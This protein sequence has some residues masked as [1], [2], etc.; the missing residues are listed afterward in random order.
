MTKFMMPIFITTY[1]RGSGE[2]VIKSIKRIVATGIVLG[3]F[4]NPAKGAITFAHIA[5]GGPPGG[6]QYKA[7]LQVSSLLDE[8]SGWKVFLYPTGNSSPSDGRWPAPYSYNGITVQDG[9]DFSFNLLPHESKFFELTGDHE[10][11]SGWMLIENYLH[12]SGDFAQNSHSSDSLAVSLFLQ[13]G[14]GKV[15]IGSTGTSQSITGREQITVPIM[16]TQSHGRQEIFGVFDG[17]VSTTVNTGVA[18]LAHSVKSTGADVVFTL[19]GENGEE[20]DRITTGVSSGN[21]HQ[22]RFIHEI[23]PGTPGD[24]IGTLRV[25]VGSRV[26]D[27]QR[28]SLED[29]EALQ[30]ELRDPPAKITGLAVRMDLIEMEQ[31]GE[32]VLTLV[33][34]SSSTAN[35]RLPRY[36]L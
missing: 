1:R 17:L 32:K 27:P 20:V 29:W 8:E 2:M 36:K 7:L 25:S 4:M 3:M 24:F 34:L 21:T 10:V 28:I 9:F 31:N 26:D 30:E 33:Y 6:G 35:H 5:L 11:R 15:L 12:P 14:E 22:A 19:F 16:R 23:F 18:W 13:W